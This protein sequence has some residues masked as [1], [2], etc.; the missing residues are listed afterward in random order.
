[1]TPLERQTLIALAV[2]PVDE[3]PMTAA[4]ISDKVAVMRGLG[5][6]QRK[7]ITETENTATRLRKLM[8]KGWV[9]RTGKSTTNAWC[10]RLTEAG[11]AALTDEMEP[12]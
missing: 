6:W 4:E 10:W 11:A 1:M 8:G 7:R 2:Y 12:Q 5:P 3:A 9:E